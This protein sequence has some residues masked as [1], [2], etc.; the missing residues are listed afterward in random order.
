MCLHT[1]SSNFVC[2]CMVA[3]SA[4]AVLHNT[5]CF[6]QL[7]QCCTTCFHQLWRCCTTCYTMSRDGAL[8]IAMSR[9]LR[10][11]ATVRGVDTDTDGYANIAAVVSELGRSVR[12]LLSC[13]NTSFKAGERRFDVYTSQHG[14]TFIRATR[15]RVVGNDG[16]IDGRVQRGRLL[17]PP[18][19]S[20]HNMPHASLAGTA[21][22]APATDRMTRAAASPAA[23]LRSGQQRSLES[24][25]PSEN[26]LPHAPV[27]ATGQHRRLSV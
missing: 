15:K 27:A 21:S 6:H 12:D 3:P 9:V 20:A 16:R 25:G 4:L 2:R 13:A 5:S 23:Q 10:Y 17:E 18:G 14:V 8:S 7:W 19:W 24:Q 22:A 1:P 26:D 11:V